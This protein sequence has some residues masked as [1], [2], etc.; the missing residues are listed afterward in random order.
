MNVALVSGR[1]SQIPFFNSFLLFTMF[2]LHGTTDAW[3][4]KF[5]LS[6]RQDQHD[7]G[8][9][10]LHSES[11]PPFSGLACDQPFLFIKAQR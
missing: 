9:H 2:G 1:R 8:S 5:G 7:G 6:K 11:I 10:H 3:K 4:A